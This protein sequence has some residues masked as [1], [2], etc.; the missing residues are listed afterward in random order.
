M[1]AEDLDERLRLAVFAHLDRLSAAYP[2]GIPSNVINTFSFDGEPMPLIVQPGIWKP[3][4][5]SAALTIRTTFTPPGQEPPYEDAV[6]SDGLVRYKWQG[7]DPMGA[8]NRALREAMHRQRPLVYFYPVAKAIY[9]ALYPV[10]LIDEDPTRHEVVL[11]TVP[12]AQ[13]AESSLE[14]QY[15]QRLTTYRLHQQVF[16]PRVLRAYRS[17]CA[18][19]RLGHA[20][21][22]DAAHIVADK[23][24]HG[25][26]VVPNGLALCKIHHAAYDVHILGVRPDHVVEVR[27]DILDEVDGP[28]LRHGLQE[29]HGARIHV[30]RAPRERPDPERLELRYERFLSAAA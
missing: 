1:A 2:D 4:S 26:P 13:S 10:Y 17:R 27:E 21:L 16:R 3:R 11:D 19:C 22:L 12:I 25:D 14:R 23:Q 29:M 30:P 6:G 28:M 18:M 5:L 8:H 20:S 7:T 24:E 9:H 15:A